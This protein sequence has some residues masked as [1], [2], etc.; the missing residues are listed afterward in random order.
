MTTLLYYASGCRVSVLA[1][2]FIAYLE[3]GPNALKALLQYRNNC[4]YNTSLV[5][6]HTILTLKVLNL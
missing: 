2:L 1:V 4:I 3:V 5:E 6:I